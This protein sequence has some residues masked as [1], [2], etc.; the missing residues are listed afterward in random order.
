MCR[1]VCPITR[2]TYGNSRGAPGT[3]RGKPDEASSP[4]PA[5]SADL[6]CPDGERA[7]RAD[8]SEVVGTPRRNVARGPRIPVTPQ[9]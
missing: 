9:H 8:I 3:P 6:H 2:D 5:D 1:R 4:S 7:G